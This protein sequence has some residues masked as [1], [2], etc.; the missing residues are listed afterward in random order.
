MFPYFYV[1]YILPLNWS[2]ASF[3]ANFAQNFWISWALRSRM[4]LTRYRIIRKYNQ[5]RKITF[6]MLFTIRNKCSVCLKYGLTQHKNRDQPC[7]YLRYFKPI[8][9]GSFFFKIT[10][11]LA[12]IQ[13]NRDLNGGN[14]SFKIKSCLLK[15]WK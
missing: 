13:C 10:T 2:Y 4:K 6:V 15:L 9:Y 8:F 5:L 3:F 11:W 7:F 1:L 12:C 14:I